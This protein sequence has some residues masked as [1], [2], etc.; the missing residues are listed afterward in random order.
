MNRI[1][2]RLVK[3]MGYEC[4]DCTCGMAVLPDDPKPEL[5]G[6]VNKLHLGDMSDSL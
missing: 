3:E 5:T 2:V 4:I 1:E 6:M